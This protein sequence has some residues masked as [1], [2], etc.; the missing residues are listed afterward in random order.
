L[1]KGRKRGQDGTTDPN[2]F[3]SLDLLFLPLHPPGPFSWV[4]LL[5]PNF[6][7]FSFVGRKEKKK[8]LST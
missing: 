7:I 3:S 6:Q 4:A 8:P 5:Y 1:L 2:L